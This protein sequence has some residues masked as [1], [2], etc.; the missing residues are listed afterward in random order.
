VSTILAENN[1]Q[2]EDLSN[3]NPLQ[4]KGPKSKESETE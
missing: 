3:L 1:N 2:E 4:E